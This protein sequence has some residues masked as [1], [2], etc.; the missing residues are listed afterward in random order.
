MGS[1][2]ATAVQN[3]PDLLDREKHHLWQCEGERCVV[4]IAMNHD[5]VMIYFEPSIQM[6]TKTLWIQWARHVTCMPDNVRQKLSSQEIRM[7]QYDVKLSGQSGLTGTR[8]YCG[9]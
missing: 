4:V 1:Y 7:R 3:G 9:V 5:L 2:T 6:I 8:V